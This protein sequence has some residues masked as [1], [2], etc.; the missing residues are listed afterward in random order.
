MGHLLSAIA[1][2][3]QGLFNKSGDS[4]ENKSSSIIIQLVLLSIFP[5]FYTLTLMPPGVSVI[6]VISA[7]VAFLLI[8]LFAV[9]VLK[10]FKIM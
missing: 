10:Y 5:V 1:K 7:G 4:K 3:I 8:V 9:K 6:E 2:Y